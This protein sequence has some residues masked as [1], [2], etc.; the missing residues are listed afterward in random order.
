MQVPASLHRAAFIFC[1]FP[2]DIPIH[3]HYITEEN[4]GI[5]KNKMDKI[6]IRFF[7]DTEVRAV[8]DE[9]HSKWWSGLQHEKRI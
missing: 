1:D 2:Y 3:I 4:R 7:N 6:S 8:W 9:E 5:I